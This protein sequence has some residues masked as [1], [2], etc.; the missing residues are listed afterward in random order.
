MAFSPTRGMVLAAGLGTRMRPLTNDRP[1]SLIE[2]AGRTLLDHAIDRFVAAGVKM[3]V[4]NVHYKGEMIIAHLKNRRD[5]E[6]RIQDE[7]DLLLDTGGALKRA[8]PQ[9]G[10]EP[11]F[12]Y[13][14]DS[15][16]LESLGSNLG[17][18]A[19]MWDDAAMDCLMLM[20]PTFNAIG[21]D[22][23]GDFT[24]DSIGRLKRREAGRVAP[25]G[26][27]GVQIIHPR[28]IARGPDGVFS[29]NRL[30]DMAIAQE[31]LFG[32]RLDGKWMHIGTP[33][34]KA[35]ADAFMAIRHHAP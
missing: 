31:R 29:T 15:I 14:S 18:M 30:W 10:N 4:V 27:P 12:T 28:L 9:F 32:I 23:K 20:A 25:F 17:R 6:I 1:K 19:A 11:V 2:V 3:V 13:N 34:A 16:W 35:E 5:V 8:L 33:E 24:M 21:F 7:R 26:W 22:S